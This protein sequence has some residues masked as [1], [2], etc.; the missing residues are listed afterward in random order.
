MTKQTCLCIARLISIRPGF[1][2]TV[3]GTSLAC[4]HQDEDWRHIGKSRLTAVMMSCSY[5]NYRTHIWMILSCQV[6]QNLPIDKYFFPLYEQNCIYY[7][8]LKCNK[9]FKLILYV[10]RCMSKILLSMG[11]KLELL[12]FDSNILNSGHLTLPRNTF[13]AVQEAK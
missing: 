7:A 4:L 1:N 10:I 13:F 2:F 3:R 12:K 5:N 6:K 8:I 9:K 11:W